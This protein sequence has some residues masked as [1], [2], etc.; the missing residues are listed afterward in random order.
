MFRPHGGSRTGS[1]RGRVYDLV[2]DNGTVVGTLKAGTVT[3][4]SGSYRQSTGSTKWTVFDP[5]TRVVVFRLRTQLRS[6]RTAPCST[7]SEA[8][9]GRQRRSGRAHSPPVP[10]RTSGP[11]GFDA[12]Q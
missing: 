2:D 8:L 1:V 10:T 7:G 9:S 11:G 6:R 3:V 4:P 5:A 12:G